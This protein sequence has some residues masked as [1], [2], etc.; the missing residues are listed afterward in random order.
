MQPEHHNLQFFVEFL[1][2]KSHRLGACPRIE[3]VGQPP[4]LLGF[5]NNFDD[6]HYFF[7][8]I[9]VLRM[10]VIIIREKDHIHKNLPIKI[11]RNL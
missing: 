2:F 6:F 8:F 5:G 9:L 4:R 3:I 1:E 10:R 11:T 7:G